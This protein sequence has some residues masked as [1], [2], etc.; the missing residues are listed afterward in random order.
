MEAVGEL[1]IFL[2][3]GDMFDSD[4]KNSA[5]CLLSR[6]AFVIEVHEGQTIASKF[7][8]TRPLAKG[9]MG[10]V[11]AAQHVTLDVPVAVKFMD[12]RYADVDELRARFEREAKAAAQLRMPNV[13]QILD[14]GV[15]ETTPYLV[16][17]F[18][19]GEDLGARLAREGRFSVSDAVPILTQIGKALRRAH[20]EGIV[21]RDLKPANVFLSDQDDEILVKVLDFG[22]AKLMRPDNVDDATKT[23]AVMGSPLYMSPEQVR[24][25]KGIDHRTDL[26]SLGVIAYR[27]LTG[28]VPFPGTVTGDVFLKICT[29]RPIRP[30]NHVPELAPSVDAFMEKALSLDPAKRFQSAKEMNEALI[31]LTRESSASVVA[32]ISA[33]MDVADAKTSPYQPGLTPDRALPSGDIRKQSTAPLIAVVAPLPQKTA[34]MIHEQPTHAPVTHPI[35]R[36]DSYREAITGPTE[37]KN[38]S[39]GVAL[40][41]AFVVVLIGLA[42]LFVNRSSATNAADT[43]TSAAASPPAP[44]STMS[45]SAPNVVPIA[46]ERTPSAPVGATAQP[47]PTDKPKDTKPATTI[48]STTPSQK[49]PAPA[50][51]PGSPWGI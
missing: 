26:W 5:S 14:Y 4:A 50:P 42:S 22:I 49:P 35:Q 20:D 44:A 2:V 30:T 43:S 47:L 33:G 18:L 28:Q 38:R 17:E 16:M 23:G 37:S 36:D 27:V 31:R 13:V 45:S 19:K 1:A 7:R 6:E 46:D 48:K 8:L 29:E 51:M 3:V 9:G 15:E 40:G 32:P 10:S 41:V 11:W 25:L 24:G 34:P 21:H 39:I 12:P